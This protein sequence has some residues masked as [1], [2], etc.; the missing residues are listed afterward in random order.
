[1]LAETAPPVSKSRTFLRPTPD[2]SKT[3]I[4]KYFPLLWFYL[5]LRFFGQNRPSALALTGC[6]QHN[7]RT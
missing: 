4:T 2:F 1:M 7:A 6:R 3:I 5:K